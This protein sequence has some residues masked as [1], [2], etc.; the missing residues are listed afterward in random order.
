MATVKTCSGELT[1]LE[2]FGGRNIVTSKEGTIMV[3]E[4]KADTLFIV[5]M[6][7][8]KSCGHRVFDEQQNN[9]EAAR[10]YINWLNRPAS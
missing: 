10:E 4:P 5:S 9:V 8:S 2:H 1:F 6:D 7:D 3:H